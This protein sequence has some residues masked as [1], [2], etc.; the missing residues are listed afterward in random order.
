MGGGGGEGEG[1]DLDT[2]PGL[3]EG[4]TPAGPQCCLVRSG[5]QVH[6]KV[7]LSLVDRTCSDLTYDNVIIVR[8]TGPGEFEQTDEQLQQCV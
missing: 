7:I 2:A 1:G 5:L 6:N 3:R 8:D 4:G